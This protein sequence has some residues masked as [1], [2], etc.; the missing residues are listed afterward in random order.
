MILANSNH[1]GRLGSDR[2]LGSAAV[3]FALIAP[4]FVLISLGMFELGRAMMVKTSLSDAAS[5]GCRADHLPQ[6]G[7]DSITAA[8]MNLMQDNGYDTT[9]FNPPWISA[10]PITVTAPDGTTLSDSLD[11]PP[12]SV[13]S[14]QVSI[15]VASTTWVTPFY[16]GSSCN[17]G[18]G[19]RYHDEAMI[20]NTFPW[21]LAARINTK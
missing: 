4:F 18:I 19:D 17:P 1:F 3:E 5:K 16:L 12:G 6:N 20:D 10:I 2:R 13:V 21:Y 14:A 9:K 8:V 15:P 11:A 7:N